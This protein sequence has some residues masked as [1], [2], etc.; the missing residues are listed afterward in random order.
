MTKNS[1]KKS[2]IAE[3]LFPRGDC[4]ARIVDHKVVDTD[5]T[6][7]QACSRSVSYPHTIYKTVPKLEVTFTDGDYFGTKEASFVLRKDKPVNQSDAEWIDALIERF[8]PEWDE[9]QQRG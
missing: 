8:R 9:Y 2:V 3:A 1:N 4:F 6:M 7:A 5:A